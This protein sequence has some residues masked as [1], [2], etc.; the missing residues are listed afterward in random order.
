MG[1]QTQ[2]VDLDDGQWAE[3]DTR[4]STKA[5]TL[6]MESFAERSRLTY[7]TI[8]EMVLASATRWSF[9]AVVSMGVLDYEVTPTQFN[10]MSHHVLELFSA[11]GGGGIEVDDEKKA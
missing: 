9:G 2:R 10:Q 7:D 1:R 6:A 4:L 5:F 8:K 3:M 11:N